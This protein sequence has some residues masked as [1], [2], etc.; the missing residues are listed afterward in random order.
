[1]ADLTPLSVLLPQLAWGYMLHHQNTSS[2]Y[3]KMAKK[4]IL[5]S[6]RAHTTDLL[7]HNIMSQPIYTL[8]TIINNLI[9][10][11]KRQ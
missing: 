4:Y 9:D 3:T 11:Y 5:H 1:M 6:N 2:L 8:C 7:Y 10:K